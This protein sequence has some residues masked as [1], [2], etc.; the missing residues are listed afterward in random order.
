LGFSLNAAIADGII[1]ATKGKANKEISYDT[2][3]AS[4]IR[5]E[6]FDKKTRTQLH[7]EYRQETNYLWCRNKRYSKE[8]YKLLK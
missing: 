1:T 2:A 5:S 3:N 6:I 7:D 8:V 4:N